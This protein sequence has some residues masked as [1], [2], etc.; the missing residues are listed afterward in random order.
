MP[1]TRAVRDL[2]AMRRGSAS[3]RMAG[4]ERALAEERADALGRAG[5][6]LEDAIDTWQLLQ[7][8]GYANDEQ[9]EAAL[10][11][12]RDAAWSLLVQRECI[13]FRQDNLGWIRRHY[14]IPPAAFARI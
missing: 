9:V 10:V 6:R 1:S 12:I 3:G 4:V 5:A 7:D 11:E 8:V 14:P 13:G 2:A